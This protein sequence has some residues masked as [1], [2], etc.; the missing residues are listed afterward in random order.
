MHRLHPR[1]H[2]GF[3]VKLQV[4]GRSLVCKAKDLSMAGLL[5]A[6][7]PVPVRSQITV[8]MPL[9]G[10][11]EVVTPCRV[12]R[13]NDQGVALEFEQLDWDDMFALARYLHPRL[14]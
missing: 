14:P 5:V 12:R 1:V 2:A 8:S 13:A 9:P 10:D 4:D 3:M 11:R 6:T 7:E